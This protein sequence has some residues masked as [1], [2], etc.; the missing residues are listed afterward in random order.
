[1]S[2]VLVIGRQGQ[3]ARALAGAAWPEGTDL[4]CQ[5]RDEIDLAKPAS[6]AHAVAARAPDLVINAAA[7]TEV[8]RAESEPALAF[9]INRDGPAALAR[10]CAALGLPLFHLSTDYVFDGRKAGAYV[11][12]DPVNPLSVYGA[13]KEAGERAVRAALPTHLILRSA[14][15]YSPEGRNFVRTMLARALEAPEIRVVDDQWGCPTAA[16]DVARAI[17]AAGTRLLAG[18]GEFGTFHFCGS[19]ST[20]WYGFA[21][22]IFQLNQGPRP[23]LI[24]VPTSAFPTPARRP[25]NSVLD[26]AKFRR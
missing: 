16:S 7:F 21:Q 24:A 6:L 1:M 3:I 17:V 23:N 15:I 5:G 25:P 18:N 10:A 8:D 14:W 11:E 22:A 2:R 19:G 26:G 4:S 13:S 12:D 9:A 20:N